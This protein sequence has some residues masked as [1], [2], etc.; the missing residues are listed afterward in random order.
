MLNISVI[1]EGV[2]TEAQR[3]FVMNLGCERIQGYLYSEPLPK[4]RYEEWIR[5]GRKPED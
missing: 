5:N 2:E 1:Q 4:E 3:E